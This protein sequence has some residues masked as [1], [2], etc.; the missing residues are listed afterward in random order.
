MEEVKSALGAPWKGERV[1][2]SDYRLGRSE[3]ILSK[4][5]PDKCRNISMKGKEIVKVGEVF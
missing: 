5:R 2:H 4:L 1:P 3:G